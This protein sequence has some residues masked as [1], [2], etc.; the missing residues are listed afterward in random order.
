MQRL[1]E[2]KTH[3]TQMAGASL[4]LSL[5]SIIQ[6]EEKLA[7]FPPLVLTKGSC[8]KRTE[9]TALKRNGEQQ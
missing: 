9:A 6:A 5:E 2:T 8:E 1:K 7:A 4:A 3:A